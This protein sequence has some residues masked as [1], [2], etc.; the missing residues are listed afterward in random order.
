MELRALACDTYGTLVDWRG[1]KLV[2]TAFVPRP[3]EY[4]PAQTSDLR[5]ESEDMEDLARALG[6]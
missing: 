5:P 1:T 3:P 6:A 2:R 4:G